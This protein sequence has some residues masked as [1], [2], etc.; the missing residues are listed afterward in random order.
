[1]RAGGRRGQ[2]VN[3]CAQRAGKPTE[4]TPHDAREPPDHG[5][6]STLGAILPFGPA[7]VKLRAPGRS[8]G[9]GLRNARAGRDRGAHRLG[10]GALRTPLLACDF[11]DSDWAC[12]YNELASSGTAGWSILCATAAEASLDDRHGPGRADVPALLCWSPGSMWHQ[13]LL[14]HSRQALGYRTPED[15]GR[16]GPCLYTSSAACGGLRRSGAWSRTLG[17]SG[18]ARAAP[19]G[20]AALPLVVAMTVRAAT[21]GT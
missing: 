9:D 17:G 11:L 2:A 15:L 21:V 12:P 19:P 3:R 16:G 5:I 8:S 6:S 4:N 1:M 13:G 10:S 14:P 18:R 7:G 20:T